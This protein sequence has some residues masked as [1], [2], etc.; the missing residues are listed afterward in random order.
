LIGHT[1]LSDD[2]D[3]ERSL[4]RHRYRLGDDHSPPRKPED[5]R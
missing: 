3:I 4:E 5:H 1:E 2:D